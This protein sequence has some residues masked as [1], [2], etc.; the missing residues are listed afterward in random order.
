MKKPF[1]HLKRHRFLIWVLALL[2]I[3][4][5]GAAI[6]GLFWSVRM[7]AA[8]PVELVPKGAGVFQA[9]VSS[10]P[11]QVFRIGEPVALKLSTGGEFFGI[12]RAVSPG[13]ERIELSFTFTGLPD[14]DAAGE[15]TIRSQR[16]LAAFLSLPPRTD[17]HFLRK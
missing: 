5:L 12:L 8:Y 1:R 2:L 14:Q 17:R 3:A 4:G 16:L 13:P 9:R 6:G 10:L 15:I 7:K 11:L